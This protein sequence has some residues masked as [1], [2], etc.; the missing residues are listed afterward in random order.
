MQAKS[1]KI[2][3]SWD[4]STGFPGTPGSA[5][6]RWFRFAGA[7]FRLFGC[8]RRRSSVLRHLA[9]GRRWIGFFFH[10]FRAGDAAGSV[11]DHLFVARLGF[12]GK[13]LVRAH[14]GF[15][16]GKI[17]DE[18]PFEFLGRRGAPNGFDMVVEGLDLAE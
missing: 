4:V 13:R 5:F 2:R 14:P 15:H 3:V 11:I 10:G 18:I 12:A 9:F 16:L 7:G 8:G 17:L 6:G 1:G